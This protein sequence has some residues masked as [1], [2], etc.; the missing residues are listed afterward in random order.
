MLR[1]D[2]GS[3]LTPA[4]GSS[5]CSLCHLHTGINALNLKDILR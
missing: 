5:K 2:G 4:G 1:A 3:R